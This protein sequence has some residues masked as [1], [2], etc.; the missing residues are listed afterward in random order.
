M[1][2]DFLLSVDFIVKYG[3]R[4]SQAMRRDHDFWSFSVTRVSLLSF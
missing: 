3:D 2:S 4:S 1:Q